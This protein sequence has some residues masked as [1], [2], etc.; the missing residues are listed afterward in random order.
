MRKKLLLLLAGFIQRS[1]H[2]Q[3]LPA[4]MD[5]YSLFGMIILP[6]WRGKLLCT[7]HLQI[8][9]NKNPQPRTVVDVQYGV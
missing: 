8:E 2:L 4:S 9:E 6:G 3:L 7:K 1:P 5:Q